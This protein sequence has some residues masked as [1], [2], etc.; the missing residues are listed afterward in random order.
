M[1]KN[2]GNKSREVSKND[3]AEILRL[4]DEHA[5]GEHSKIFATD[6]FGY[7]T[8]TVE[9]PLRA[10][11]GE[12]VRDRKGNAKPDSKLRDTENVPFTY[13]GNEEGQSVR[14]AV[15]QAYFDAEVA[16]HVPDAWVDEAKTKV[17]YEIPF[18]RHFY[19]YKPPRPLEEIDR[20]LNVLVGEIME[21][22]KDVER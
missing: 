22:L 19:V 8:I 12:I 14:D 11:N 18:T 6:A 1:R 15:I 16:P 7:W 5:E 17:G 3:R 4:Y 13:G 10:G 2:L 20:D 21:L 9:R